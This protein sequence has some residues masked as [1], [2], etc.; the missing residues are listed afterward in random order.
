VVLVTTSPGG[1]GKGGRQMDFKHCWQA[2]QDIYSHVGLDEAEVLYRE[3]CKAKDSIVHIGTL[4]GRSVAI[5]CLANTS[6]VTHAVDPWDV[7]LLWGKVVK[8]MSDNG[9]E[10]FKGAFLDNMSLLNIS[11]VVHDGSSQNVVSKFDDNTIDL[12]FIDGDHS[13]KAVEQDISLWY[14]KLKPN[15][16]IL[17]HDWNHSSVQNAVRSLITV[18]EHGACWFLHQ[19]GIDA[20][21]ITTEGYDCEP[22]FLK[23]LPSL[24]QFNSDDNVII[25]TYPSTDNT[26]EL[27]D[28]YC[29]RH[30]NWQHFTYNKKLCLSEALNR[31]I[32]FCVK[33]LDFNDLVHLDSDCEVLHTKW[34]EGLRVVMDDDTWRVDAMGIVGRQQRLTRGGHYCCLMRGDVFKEHGLRYDENFTERS[35]D[36]DLNYRVGVDTGLV[37]KHAPSVVVRHYNENFGMKSTQHRAWHVLQA[38]L[39]LVKKYP[40]SGE[41][42]HEL[43]VKRIQR[44]LKLWKLSKDDI[45]LVYESI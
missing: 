29:S 9:I 39:H 25:L 37:K 6:A 18:H 42:L 23:L 8:Y 15:G 16:V 3:S 31:A 32:D 40:V 26:I 14:D 12:I 7:Q 41:G 24:E 11:P 38:G 27:V 20:N 1:Q 13:R 45:A 34:V 22:N 44:A 36:I 19:K 21:Y 33:R 10:D 4:F 35:Q 28:S 5:S 17:G 30:A 2:I 43:G